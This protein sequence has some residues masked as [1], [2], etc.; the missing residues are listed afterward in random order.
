[1]FVRSDTRLDAAEVT[2]TGSSRTACEHSEVYI[3]KPNGRCGGN[4]NR[5]AHATTYLS[6]LSPAHCY[7]RQYVAGTTNTAVALSS[8]NAE[9]D[10]SLDQL[11]SCTA[12][13]KRT[14]N[15]QSRAAMRLES[16]VLL[17]PRGRSRRGNLATGGLR[18]R[19]STRTG[20]GACSLQ[21]CL[22]QA[23]CL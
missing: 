2:G 9:G 11:R 14:L 10:V 7:N 6:F 16:Q 22:A 4:C 19:F 15:R 23:G 17:I 5:L 12:V 1:M 18:A 8:V 21:A 13:R 20:F 3:C